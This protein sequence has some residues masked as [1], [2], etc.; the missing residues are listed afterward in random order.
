MQEP[1]LYFIRRNP[2]SLDND[3]E[4]IGSDGAAEEALHLWGYW[5]AIRKHLSLIAG[6]VGAVV[7]VTMLRVFTM[8]PTYT[9]RSTILVERN[10]PKVLAI[11]DLLTE[12]DEADAYYRTQYGILKSRSLAATEIR[13]EG[14]DANG[15]FAGTKSESG[16]IAGV[17]AG[18]VGAMRR[19]MAAFD[20]SGRL[21]GTA[22]A[23]VEAGSIDAYLSRLDVTP[24]QG[25]R[26]VKIAYSSADPELSARIANA[27]GMA[28]IRQGLGL[29]ADASGEAQRFLDEKLVELKDR[30]EKSEAALNNYRRDKG[31]ISLSGR[32]NIVV[33][34]LS[35]LNKE[36][37]DAEA[38][39]IAL[40]A[41]VKL[42]RERSYD[43]IPEVVNSTLIQSLKQNLI[44][45][46]TQYASLSRQFKSNYPPLGQLEAQIEENRNR[47]AREVERVVGGIQSAYLAAATKENEFHE[48][49]KEQQRLALGLKDASAEYA[50][51]EREVDTNRQLY[52]SVL[53]RIKE[54]GVSTAVRVSN[55]SII[56]RAEPPPNPSSP[57][58][59]QSL[60][61]SVLIGLSGG[62]AA[63]LLLEY[64]D[65]TLKNPEE[66][67]RYLRLPSL[68]IVPRFA[69]SNNG[70][71]VARNLSGDRAKANGRAERANEPI[72]LTDSSPVA[73]EAYRALRTAI[74]LS[75]AA[76]P[77]KAILFTSATDSE[78]KTITTLNAAVAFARLGV[79]VCVIDA[80]LRRPRCHK[81]LRLAGHPGLTEVLIGQRWVEEVIQPTGVN[82]L[83]LISAGSRPPNSTELLGSRQMRETLDYVNQHFDH[84]LIDCSPV[85][86]VSDALLVSTMVDGVVLVV[87]GHHTP[88]QAVKAA[89]ARLDHARAKIFGVLLNQVD[90]R[91]PDLAYYNHYGY[92][93]SR[94][95]DPHPLDVE[96]QEA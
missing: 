27:H 64:L 29:Y 5:R 24:V 87:N 2:A 74:L 33:D 14:L 44:Q 58:K 49:L 17:W 6:I 51:L 89:C 15:F 85:M 47:L 82:N 54:M 62:I 81:L 57:R 83:F 8:T 4:L 23:K 69:A 71:A 53:Q 35:D 84:V 72:L 67:E 86:P 37:T 75:R 12:T 36:L 92:Y 70:S 38:D 55:V 95:R 59:A 61:I 43:Y 48:K 63:A 10:F 45:L 26:L 9:A 3:F 91:S 93:C 52:D 80:D 22:P 30:V 42:V 50:I 18:A 28:Y 77:P 65:N 88:K 40:Q 19:A 56:D 1:S 76:G 32:E 31:I 60:L 41:E 94:Y 46:E 20:E 73:T 68:G 66:V 90:L 34:R 25:T 78:G 79:R 21:A 13:Q 7:V 11:N 16:L 96:A 39:R